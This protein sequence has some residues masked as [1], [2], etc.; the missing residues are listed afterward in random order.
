MFIDSSIDDILELN[1]D[2]TIIEE[3][4]NDDLIIFDSK[5]LNDSKSQR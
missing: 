3:E 2:Q 5:K 1:Q 4:S